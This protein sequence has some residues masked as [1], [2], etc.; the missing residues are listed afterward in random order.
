M[1]KRS[2]MSLTGYRRITG[3]LQSNSPNQD[4][5]VFFAK[6]REGNTMQASFESEC[7]HSVNTWDFFPNVH[8]QTLWDK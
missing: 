7:Q 5:N 1:R 8:I 3:E 2:S 4:I 6:G